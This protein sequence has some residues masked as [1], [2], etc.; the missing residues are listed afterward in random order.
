MFSVKKLSILLLLFGISFAQGVGEE[1]IDN[2]TQVVESPLPDIPE[3]SSVVIVIPPVPEATSV[4]VEPPVETPVTIESPV[5]VEVVESPTVIV[6]EEVVE[7]P[8]VIVEDTGTGDN[9]NGNDNDNG[10][11]NG[12]GNGND[13]DNGGSDNGGSDKGGSDNGGTDN[14]D[15]G[16]GQQQQQQ[17][18]QQQQNQQSRQQQ[19][20]NNNVNNANNGNANN[21]NGNPDT[22]TNDDDPVTNPTDAAADDEEV[23]DDVSGE[24]TTSS[25]SA[26]ITGTVNSEAGQANGGGFVTSTES[27]FGA[28]ETSKSVGV[29]VGVVAGVVAS[30][31]VC[32]ALVA[33]L[34]VRR[35]QKKEEHR[36]SYSPFKI[37]NGSNLVVNTPASPTPPSR[38]SSMSRSIPPAD[39]ELPSFAISPP[40]TNPQGSYMYPQSEM[41][42]N[43]YP[44]HEA[45]QMPALADYR[46]QDG[47]SVYTA[48]EGGPPSFFFP[49]DYSVASLNPESV[50]PAST[51]IMQEDHSFNPYASNFSSE[52]DLEFTEDDEGEFDGDHE[53]VSIYSQSSYATDFRASMAPSMMSEYEERSTSGAHKSVY[54]AWGGESSVGANNK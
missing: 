49:Q 15:S 44:E 12:N 3:E 45:Y 54:S 39:P 28:E 1:T 9:G 43:Q 4:V 37:S 26:A 23:D 46:P 21:G 10:N 47:E 14:T 6:D 25:I 41:Q 16:N 11:G 20:N 30:V 38:Y 35:N 2:S 18:Q 33:G 52:G 7:T 50:P 53:V 13:N 34:L 22:T 48:A 24:E 36:Q 27:T 51:M 29:S 19:N 32:V 40:Q 8:V 5:V 31:C 42:N 17:G